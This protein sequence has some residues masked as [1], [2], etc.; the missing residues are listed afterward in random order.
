MSLVV[1]TDGAPERAIA[2][3]RSAIVTVNPKLAVFNI[4]TMEQL[5]DD[6]LWQLNLYRW[7][8][9]LF[10]ALTLILAAIGLYGMIS[11]TASARARE[12]AI[13]LALG[14]GKRALA[15]LVLGR[16]LQLAAAGLVV[17]VVAVMALTWWFADLPATIRP[18]VVICA[19]V[20]A[21]VILIALVAC[22]APSMRAASIDPAVALRQG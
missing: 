14:S 6:S 1:R 10:A 15:Q 17:G 12:F 5:L 3:I 13:R 4:R 2:S 18:D 22:A 9:G 21:V 7:L 8:I 16:G 11:Y 19:A 20:S